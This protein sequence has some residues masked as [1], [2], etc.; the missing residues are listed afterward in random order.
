M[1]RDS[2]LGESAITDFAT[3]HFN[4]LEMSAVIMMHGSAAELRRALVCPCAR[5]ETGQGAAGCPACNG[6]GFVF[7]L[8]ERCRTTLLDHSR[9][10][11]YAILAEGAH[12]TGDLSVTFPSGVLPGHGDMVLPECE[13]H[14]VLEHFHRATA[15]VDIVPIEERRRSRDVPLHVVRP[16]AERLLYPSVT[17]LESCYWLDAEGDLVRGVDG[18]DFVLDRRAGGVY[19]RWLSEIRGPERGKGYS[20]R[21]Q[22]PAAYLVKMAA[23]RFRHEAGVPMPYFCVLDRLDRRSERDLVDNQGPTP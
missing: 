5:I 8:P 4:P 15:Q 22:A 18:S 9:N 21:Y 23:P 2:I 3:L 6:L 11:K 19:V 20:I 13:T 7:P 12:V 1:A 17:A 16:R 14:V 10:P